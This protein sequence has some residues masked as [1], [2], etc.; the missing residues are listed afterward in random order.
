MSVFLQETMETSAEKLTSTES[1]KR[2]SFLVDVHSLSANEM[3]AVAPASAMTLRFALAPPPPP[4]VPNPVL[5]S[6]DEWRRVKAKTTTAR[7]AKCAVGNTA[8]IRFEACWANAPIRAVAIV[9][10]ATSA[11]NDA[12]R[13]LGACRNGNVEGAWWWIGMWPAR[14]ELCRR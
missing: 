14:V 11:D 3:A 9:D 8:T 5:P 6:V 2:W 12:T 4:A 7:S 1:H 13:S 10:K